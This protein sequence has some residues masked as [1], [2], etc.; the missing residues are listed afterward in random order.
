MITYVNHKM[1]ASVL[2]T[3][4]GVGT[5]NLPI[6][7]LDV[8]GGTDETPVVDDEVVIADSDASGAT[9]KA[10]IS[11]SRLNLR[12]CR[13]SNL[14]VLRAMSSRNSVTLGTHTTVN[15]IATLADAGNDFTISNS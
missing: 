5:G 6:A 13:S 12:R 1:S 2:K 11:Y 15:Y 9:K 4:L 10:D 3:Y 14:V 8:D 7:N